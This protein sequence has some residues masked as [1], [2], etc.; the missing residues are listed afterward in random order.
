MMHHGQG[1]S[2]FAGSSSLKLNE[3]DA[4][5]MNSFSAHSGSAGI[6]LY[7]AEMPCQDCG[8]G[9]SQCSPCVTKTHRTSSP[10]TL[11]HKL[12]L[13]CDRTSNIISLTS[14]GHFSDRLHGPALQVNNRFSRPFPTSLPIVCLPVSQFSKLQDVEIC[15]SIR[16]Q[17]HGR[18]RLVPKQTKRCS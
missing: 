4:P 9:R 17:A 2:C 12:L 5:K 16:P 7:S 1:L 14:C 3:Q 11:C 15:T 6:T 13:A 8:D 10:Q 18:T